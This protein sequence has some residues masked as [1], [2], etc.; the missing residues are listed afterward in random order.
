[1]GRGT[2]REGWAGRTEKEKMM[3]GADGDEGICVD[4]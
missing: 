1:M 2:V 4:S 3:I